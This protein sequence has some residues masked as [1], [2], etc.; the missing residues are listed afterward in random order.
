MKTKKK[1]DYIVAILIFVI[2]SGIAF[3]QSKIKFPFKGKVTGDNVNVRSGPDINYY[4][5]IRLMK[6]NVVDVAGQEYGWYKIVPPAGS[7]SWVSKSC[8]EK[9]DDKKG[10]ISKDRVAIRAGSKFTSK[11]TAIQMIAKKGLEIEILGQDGQYYKITPPEGA[12]LWISVD[13]VK[14]IIEKKSADSTGIAGKAKSGR[15]KSSSEVPEIVE[16]VTTQPALGVATRPSAKIVR[17]V[18]K[19]K[20]VE[21]GIFGKYSERIEQLDKLYKKELTKPLMERQF[22]RIVEGFKKI[23]NQK[24]IPLAAAYARQRLEIIDYQIQAQ[25]GYQELREIQKQFEE[26]SKKMEVQQAQT[27]LEQMRSPKLYKAAGI[28]EKSYVFTGPLMPKRYRLIDP[29]KNSTIAYVE[30]ADEAKTNVDDYLGKYVGVYGTVRYD[31]KLR[32]DIITAAAFKVLR[33]PAV[34]SKPAKEKKSSDKK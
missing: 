18:V 15:E 16:T 31:A 12:Y 22:G 34:T 33:I 4:S 20:K 9:I 17:K 14:P 32:I 3:G 7:F 24:E 30:L 27:E 21:E 10:I 23:A 6:G 29:N 11:K 19:K 1:Y 28:L 2:V 25:K 13:Y 8:V 26:Q 5:T